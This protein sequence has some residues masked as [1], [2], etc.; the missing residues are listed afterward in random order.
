MS[1]FSRGAICVPLDDQENIMCTLPSHIA[2]RTVV[3]IS[4]GRVRIYSS[5]DCG[6]YMYMRREFYAAPHCNVMV[7][8]SPSKTKIMT[9][10]RWRAP[11]NYNW[12]RNRSVSYTVAR[13]SYYVAL[14]PY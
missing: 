3:A 7:L 4:E 13:W 12:Y 2:T 1:L 9:I 14:I 5:C 10:V 8:V 6:S 11:L